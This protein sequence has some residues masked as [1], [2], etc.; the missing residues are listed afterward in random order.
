MNLSL[1]PI[2]KL[3][4]LKIYTINENYL[5]KNFEVP[6]EDVALLKNS[7][8]LW[9]NSARTTE[10]I[11]PILFHYSWLCFN[12]FFAYTFFR[13]GQK[14]SQSHGVYVSNMND[15]IE[16]I[17]ISISKRN[18]IFQRRWIRGLL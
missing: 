15:N 12:S 10:A 4:T 1:N 9:R 3:Q 17:K 18:G 13:W 11:A 5:N 8:E 2:E 14:H 16:K 6:E 7:I